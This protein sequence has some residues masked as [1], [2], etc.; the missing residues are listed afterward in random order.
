MTALA[1]TIGILCQFLMVGGQLL[2]KRGMTAVDR[3][4]RVWARVG[5]N[6]GGGLVALSLW[7]FL[8]LGLLQEWEISRLFPFEGLTS[9]LLVLAAWLVLGERLPRSAWLGIAL[10]GAGIA[11]VAAS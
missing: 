5:W 11:L 1:I 6:L 4:P 2:L 10:I 3:V 7:F 9:V 8:W